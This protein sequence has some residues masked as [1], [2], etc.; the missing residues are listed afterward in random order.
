MTDEEMIQNQAPLVATQV[1]I[2][3]L[4]YLLIVVRQ[5]RMIFWS[6][7][8]TFALACGITLLMPNI[9]TA[10]ASFLSSKDNKG[11][12]GTITGSLGELSALAG[13]S[14]GE[15]PGGLYVGML[16]GRTISDAVIDHFNLME[17]YD[18]EY[19]VKAYAAL[20]DHV[21][22][23]LGKDDGIIS[24]TV[25]DEDP[26]RAAEIANYFVDELKK[27]NIDLNLNSAGRERQFLED[28]LTL[29]KRDL[30]EAE[31]NLK[32]FQ[33][34]N[35][36]IRLDDQASAIIDA[37]AK[38]KGDLASKEIELGVLL[39]YQTKQNPQVKALREGI[40]RLE[41]QI[42]KLEQSSP[43]KVFSGDI[44]IA[45]AEVP[46]L[47][48]Q[49]SR[50][51]RNFKVQETLFELL[52]KQFEVAKISEARNTST[53]QV[54]DVAVPPDQKSRPKRALLVLL[55]TFSAG[56]LAVLFAFVR[57]FAARMTDQDKAYLAE[58]KDHLRIWRK[59]LKSSTPN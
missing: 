1:E 7:V 26:K 39:S 23:S 4:G 43:D 42:R 37:I 52:T 29:I 30:T 18:Q 46:K 49:Y 8:A 22:I 45:T 55:A 50:L 36:A 44:F 35:R 15:S 12:L 13:L 3:L 2:N 54:L 53:I 19:R 6:G 10:T 5:K 28:R 17:I 14:I 24:I 16:K 58:I 40:D 33:E 59:H 31:E 11:S 27:L 51:L 48:V 34:S 47:G 20:A 57:E 21:N 41:E 9:Y 56:F 32:E 25:E 38:L